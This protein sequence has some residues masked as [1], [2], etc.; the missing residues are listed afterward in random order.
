MLKKLTNILMILLI[1]SACNKEFNETAL[2][3]PPNFDKMPI[4]NSSNKDKIVQKSGNK[5]TEQDVSDI[6]KLLLN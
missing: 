3:I 1:F 4:I 6:K 2:L 5:I